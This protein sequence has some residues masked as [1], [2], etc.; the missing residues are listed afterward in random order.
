M[1]RSKAAMQPDLLFIMNRGR[2]IWF[3]VDSSY[4]VDDVKRKI[5]ETLGVRPD[6][7]AIFYRNE[8]LRD[9][10]TLEAY[11]IANASELRLQVISPEP[12]DFSLA[13]ADEDGRRGLHRAAAEGN[14]KLVKWLID[15]KKA[16][17]NAKDH[18]SET[19]LHAAAYKG[20]FEVVKFL[21]ENNVDVNVMDIFGMTALK[22]AMDHCKRSGSLGKDKAKDY[23]EIVKLLKAKTNVKKKK[24]CNLM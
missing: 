1:C 15:S 9:G 17:I 8:R 21:V 5:F 23:V 22:I 24:G 2:L 16:H 20:N 13:E 3:L 12:S 19:A 6:Q 14:L 10:R 11:N 7:Q 4:T 18:S